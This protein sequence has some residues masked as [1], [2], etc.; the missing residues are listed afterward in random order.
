MSLTDT[1]KMGLFYFQG[2][3]EPI[4]TEFL[5][6]DCRRNTGVTR[7]KLINRESRGSLGGAV[8]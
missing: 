1:M 2:H 8:V 6:R 7:K 3:G 5:D 4:R